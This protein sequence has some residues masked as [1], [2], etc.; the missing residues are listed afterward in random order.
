ML[1]HSLYDI[2][3]IINPNTVIGFNK[4]VLVLYKPMCIGQRCLLKEEQPA[5]LETHIPRLSIHDL[6]IT[7]VTLS[8]ARSQT[9][10]V[11]KCLS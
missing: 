11:Q 7:A 10:M 3:N 8:E 1:M 9:T 6:S 4:A 5:H 2:V